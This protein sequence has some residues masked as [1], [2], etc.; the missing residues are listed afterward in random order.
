MRKVKTTC[1]AMFPNST[2]AMIWISQNCDKCWKKSKYSE[3]TDRWSNDKC[4]IDRDIQVQIAGFHLITERSYKI[5]K[6]NIIC[7]NRQPV[8]P[9][10]H[11]KRTK[12]NQVNIFNQI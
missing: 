10:I 11:K 4:S 3:S 6:N 8:K 9:T 2:E 12:K 7:P 5:V 1:E